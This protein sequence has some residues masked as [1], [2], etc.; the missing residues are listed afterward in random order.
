M[1]FGILLRV[2][3]NRRGFFGHAWPHERVLLVLDKLLDA[4]CK[5]EGICANDDIE[6]YATA[7]NMYYHGYLVQLKQC[8]QPLSSIAYICPRNHMVS[9]KVQDV[10]PRHHTWLA[11]ALLN[12]MKFSY[13][14]ATFVQA[15]LMAWTTLVAARRCIAYVF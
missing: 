7:R 11:T 9:I 2:I 15:R 6:V 12:I 13:M 5:A 14:V 4:N 10:C 8:A 3:R 1:A